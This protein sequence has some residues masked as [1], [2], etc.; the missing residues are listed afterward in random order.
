MVEYYQ[1]LSRDL[2]QFLQLSF[3]IAKDKRYRDGLLKSK[4]I[5]KSNLK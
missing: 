1:R 4:A 5:Q 2:Q 3:I